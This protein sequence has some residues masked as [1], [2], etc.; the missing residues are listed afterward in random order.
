MRNIIVTCGV[1]ALLVVGVNAQDKTV[2][3]PDR[4]ILGEQARI[5]MAPPAVAPT[6]R[7]FVY[8]WPWWMHGART[9]CFAV[10]GPVG[11]WGLEQS[12]LHPPLWGHLETT[13]GELFNTRDRR[14]ALRHS[15][16]KNSP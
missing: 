2:I 7:V 16:V 10:C 11:P 13:G 15:A 5:L 12:A 8:G 6:V 4:L 14:P 1:V 9:P 3:D